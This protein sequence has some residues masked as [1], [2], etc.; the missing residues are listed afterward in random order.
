MGDLSFLGNVYTLLTTAGLIGMM[1]SSVSI[2]TIATEGR[3]EK[4]PGGR[5]HL[6]LFALSLLTLYLMFFVV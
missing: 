5:F 1:I 6:S 3:H 2:Y 4:T